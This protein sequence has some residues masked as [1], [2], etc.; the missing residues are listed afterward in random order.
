MEMVDK[1][2]SAYRTGQIRRPR[3]SLSAGVMPELL[4]SQGSAGW[5]G[6]EQRKEVF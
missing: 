2:K 5:V 6:W 3:G 1:K 4:N